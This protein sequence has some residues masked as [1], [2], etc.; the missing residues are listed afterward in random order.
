MSMGDVIWDLI[1]SIGNILARWVPF[2]A[3]CFKRNLAAAQQ[4]GIR[5]HTLFTQHP[6]NGPLIALSA[7]ERK[8]PGTPI[9]RARRPARRGRTQKGAR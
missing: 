4:I 6:P 9:D 7:P 2:F 3:V 5:P 1:E 8:A